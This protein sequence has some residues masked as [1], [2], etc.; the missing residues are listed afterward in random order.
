MSHRG[1]R[2]SAVPMLLVRRKPHH[3]AGPD[4]LDRAAPPL[5][6]S[7]TGGDDQRLT[8]WMCMPG[9]ACTRLERDACATHTCWFRRLEQ[10]INA[11]RTRETNQLGLCSKFANQIFLFPSDKRRCFA[12]ALN[13]ELSR[14][15]DKI[16]AVLGLT[17]SRDQWKR[18]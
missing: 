3:I 7:E 1:R 4:F 17:A 12:L 5:R 6:P 18:R 8:K 10:R 15:F 11:H 13:F 14:I 2:R 9:R 16:A